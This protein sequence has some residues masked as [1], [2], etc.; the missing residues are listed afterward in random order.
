TVFRGQAISAYSRR[1]SPSKPPL[2]L[3]ALKAWFIKTGGIWRVDDFSPLFREQ[4]AHIVPY[5]LIL[6]PRNEPHT[7]KAS[8]Q[9]FLDW[10]E[11]SPE[12]MHRSLFPLLEAQMTQHEPGT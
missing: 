9:A 11:K 5:E 6:S 1:D 10:L 8:L 4:L 12:P 7:T 3:P 2:S